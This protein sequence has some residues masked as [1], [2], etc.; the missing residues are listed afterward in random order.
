[1][2]SE[3]QTKFTMKNDKSYQLTNCD[4]NCESNKVEVVLT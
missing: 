4:R 2:V 1:M 3:C